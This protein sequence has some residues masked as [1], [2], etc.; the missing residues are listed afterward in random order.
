MKVAVVVH[1]HTGNTFSVAEKVLEEIVEKGHQA[2]MLRIKPID[3]PGSLKG[4]C[5]LEYKPDISEYEVVIF[6][7][8]VWGFALS[9]VMREYL[10]QLGTLKDKKIYC[11]VTQSFPFEFLGGNNAIKQMV[12]K[13]QEKEGIVANTK[14]VNWNTEKKRQRKIKELMDI[15]KDI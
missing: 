4:K 5:E 14:V 12:K 1:S 2:D 3:E 15:V 6:A 10:N 11:F 8:P 7:A 13:T 9:G